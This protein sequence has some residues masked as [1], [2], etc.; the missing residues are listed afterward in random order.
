MRAEFKRHS[1]LPNW[2]VVEEDVRQP[3]VELQRRLAEEIARRE[4][5]ESLVP[6]DRDPVPQQYREMV[7]KYYERLG[8]GGEP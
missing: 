2:D 6:T 7:R 1:K 5:P 4:S 3:L 8:G